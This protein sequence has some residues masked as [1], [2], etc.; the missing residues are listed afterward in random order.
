MKSAKHIDCRLS[1]RFS[2][3]SILL[4]ANTFVSSGCI[5]AKIDNDFNILV[6]FFFTLV[7]RYTTSIFQSQISKGNTLLIASCADSS[8]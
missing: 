5:F 3:L 8:P 6:L 4:A 1:A 7:G 2:Y